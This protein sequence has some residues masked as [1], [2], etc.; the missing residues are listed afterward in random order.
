MRAE[1]S[2]GRSSPM[3]ETIHSPSTLRST[4][5]C[6]NFQF[7]IFGHTPLSTLRCIVRSSL[8]CALLL[9]CVICILFPF[10]EQRFEDISNYG[11]SW[12]ISEWFSMMSPP[13]PNVSYFEYSTPSKYIKVHD[14][15]LK[16]DVMIS[17]VLFQCSVLHWTKTIQKYCTGKLQESG[18]G[19]ESAVECS[20]VQLGAAVGLALLALLA[21]WMCSLTPPPLTLT[22]WMAMLHECAAVPC[23]LVTSMMMIIMMMMI[24]VG[25]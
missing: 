13:G 11:E 12:W 14:I 18:W 9:S 7:H 17:P 25:N 6:F 23:R 10:P 3:N 22:I 2:Q 15:K 5:M 21:L 4:R 19:W 24:L 16:F 20:R 8:L 1:H